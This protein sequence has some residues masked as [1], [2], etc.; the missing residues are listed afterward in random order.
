MTILGKHTIP[1]VEELI[2]N[3]QNRI[4]DVGDTF[5]KLDAETLAKDA[6]LDSEW[7]AFLERWTKGKASARNMLVAAKLASPTVPNDIVPVEGTWTDVLKLANTSYPGPYKTTDLPGLQIRVQKLKPIEWKAVEKN[8]VDAP[9][10][11]LKTY[12]KV[13]QTI[14]DGEQGADS[15]LK[16]N[17]GKIAIGVGAGIGTVILLRKL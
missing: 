7:K 14:K 6:S 17:W 3:L 2:G 13:D 9:D 1:E 12:K 5:A 16:D 10:S 15:I 4:T 11:D 8:R